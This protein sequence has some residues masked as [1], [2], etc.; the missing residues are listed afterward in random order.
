MISLYDYTK[1]K[2][3]IPNVTKK[4][5]SVCSLDLV[6]FSVECRGVE[7]V[8]KSRLR[9]VSYLLLTHANLSIFAVCRDA[10]VVESQD[11]ET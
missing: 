6:I 8:L 10:V 2:S 3:Q 7:A 4:K 1:K 9:R 5:N 11:P